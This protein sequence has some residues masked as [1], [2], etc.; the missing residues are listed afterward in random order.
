MDADTVIELGRQALWTALLIGAPILLVGVAI[1]LLTGVLQTLTQ[2]QDQTV[3]F[4]PKVVGMVL[5]LAVSL[6]W[7]LQLLTD[8]SR[9]LFENIPRLVM[10]H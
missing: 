10:G 4:V 2:V 7:L 8:Y 5:A 9:E 6:P 3:S 1:G